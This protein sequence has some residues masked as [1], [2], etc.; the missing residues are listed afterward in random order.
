[1]SQQATYSPPDVVQQVAARPASPEQQRVRRLH[2]KK[3]SSK[4]SGVHTTFQERLEVKQYL[5]NRKKPN[6]KID[7]SGC[8]AE[9]N[10]SKHAVSRINKLSETALLGHDVGSR[11]KMD[12]I[13]LAQ[14]FRAKPGFQE[15]P[16]RKLAATFTDENRPISK[17]AL[18]LVRAEAERLADCNETVVAA[19]NCSSSNAGWTL[20][21]IGGTSFNPD[22]CIQKAYQQHA[23]GAKAA[24]STAVTTTL[25]LMEKATDRLGDT[26]T[27]D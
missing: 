22:L 5:R 11:R 16:L 13:E 9:N 4:S 24:S 15:M 25:V 26:R 20:T 3:V 1:M 18:A 19:E 17:S 21:L 27:T 2:G 8:A 10:L 23:D 14:R 6:G 7:I 12:P